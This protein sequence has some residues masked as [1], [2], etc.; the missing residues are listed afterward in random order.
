MW[1]T[2][3]R[4]CIQVHILSTLHAIMSDGAD[5]IEGIW[6]AFR[7]KMGDS[8]IVRVPMGFFLSRPDAVFVC[9]EKASRDKGKGPRWRYLGGALDPS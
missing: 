6:R 3:W 8:Q 7:T 4:I 2:A 1:I 9:F 5:A